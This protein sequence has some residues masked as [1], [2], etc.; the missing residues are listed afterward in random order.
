[1]TPRGLTVLAPLRPGSDALLRPVLRAIGDDIRGRR[2][3]NDGPRQPHIDFTGST[4]IHFARFAIL[5]DPDRGPG[6]TRLLYSSNY[7]GDLG[8]HLTALVDATSDMAAVWGHCEGYSTPDRFADFI[9]A[10]AIEPQAFYIAFRDGSVAQVRDEAALR[11]KEQA[12]VDEAM[13]GG[14]WPAHDTRPRVWPRARVT[15]LRRIVQRNAA[16]VRTLVRAAPLPADLLRATLRHGPRNVWWAGRTIVAS[17][18]RMPLPRMFNRVTRNRMPPMGTAYSSAPL[19][20]A[21]RVRPVRAEGDD[22][23]PSFRE[24]AVAQNQLTLLTPVGPDRVGRLRAVLTGIDTYARRLSPPGQLLGISTIH[25][26]RWLLI[27]NDRQLLMLSDYD[28]SWEAYIDEFAELILSGLDAIWN[29]APVYP[30]DGAR[31]LPAFKAF[32]RSHQVPAEIFYSGYPAATTLHVL[33]N[34]ERARATR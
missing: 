12:R 17:L 7:D 22:L 25:F 31:D 23:P 34:R 11:R 15:P 27:D 3:S 13:T 6:R 14:A 16:H 10:H 19:D 2:L 30:P 33:A 26:V 24:D 9:S 32:L 28:G 8:S 1:M 18:D 20:Q 4:R 5:P 29:S 21:A